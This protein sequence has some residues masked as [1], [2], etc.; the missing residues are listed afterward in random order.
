MKTAIPLTASTPK[1]S[2]TGT[3]WTVHKLGGTE[4]QE[5]L[6]GAGWFAHVTHFGFVF[7]FIVLLC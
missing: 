7:V 2:N 1:N 5:P 3:N 4:A 6:G